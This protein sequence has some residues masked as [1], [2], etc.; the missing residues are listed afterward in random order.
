MAGEHTVSRDGSDPNVGAGHR[1][2]L[3]RSLEA[4][5]RRLRTEHLDLYRVHRWDRHTPIQ[6]TMRALDEAA[7][8]GKIL[9]VGLSDA[10]TDLTLGLLGHFLAQA[11]PAV[12]GEPSARLDGRPLP[13]T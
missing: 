6:E 2:N 8:A 10:A 1:E 7:R 13:W 11:G 3:T 4:G 12:F 5:L 9:Q